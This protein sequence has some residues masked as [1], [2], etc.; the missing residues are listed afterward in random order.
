MVAYLF[1]MLLPHK[2]NS[3]NTNINQIKKSLQARYW[4]IIRAFLIKF[5]WH[6]NNWQMTEEVIVPIPV[7]LN[8][9]NDRK[10]LEEAPTKFPD[11]FERM[12]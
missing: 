10:V 4:N 6:F 9:S 3:I 2:E 7:V 8:P 12:E 1:A 11:M 5:N